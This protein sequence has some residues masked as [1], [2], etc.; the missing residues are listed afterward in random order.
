MLNSS[1]VPWSI[2]VCPRLQWRMTVLGEIAV[3]VRSTETIES[4]FYYCSNVLL[5]PS[6]SLSEKEGD[7]D[8]S[9]EGH[10]VTGS[11]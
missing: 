8:R 3:R 2:T 5:S 7:T 1:T 6:R 11:W 10:R 4:G 9:P